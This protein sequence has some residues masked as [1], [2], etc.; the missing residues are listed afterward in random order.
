MP[1]L[2]ESF[3]VVTFDRR[4]HSQSESASTQGS[5]AEDA[6]DLGSLIDALGLAPAHVV[7]TSG[8]AIIALRLAAKRPELFRTLLVHE[9]PLLGLLE[10][11]AAFKPM[12]DEFQEPLHAV[13]ELLQ[14][15]D[16]QAAARY[17]VEHVA[18][19]AGAWDTLPPPVRETFIHNAPTFLDETRDPDGLTSDLPF[20]CRFDRPTLV[21]AGTESPPFFKPIVDL[22]AHALPMSSVHVYAGAG[23]APHLSH[24]A[25]YVETVR[26]FCS[27]AE[28]AQVVPST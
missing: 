13:V 2:S 9:P 16:H 24:P 8:G 14:A 23:H 28:S 4:G 25:A 7:G 27:K 20:L 11:Q 18:F 21:T 22:V 5:F 19:G 6:N 3:E 10:G 26:Q 15:G 12:I 1:L 17:F